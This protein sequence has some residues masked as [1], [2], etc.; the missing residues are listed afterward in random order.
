MN[1]LASS[2]GDPFPNPGD[3]RDE[4]PDAVLHFPIDD[5]PTLAVVAPDDR[6]DLVGGIRTGRSLHSNP[7]CWMP[8]VGMIW[9]IGSMK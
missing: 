9:R 4:P 3:D 8:S 6:N 2:A 1:G 5:R 7:P